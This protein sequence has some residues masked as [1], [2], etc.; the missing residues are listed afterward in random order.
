MGFRSY[1]IGDSSDG[2]RDAGAVLGGLSDE[3]Q[4]GTVPGGADLD[5]GHCRE[6]FLIQR[7]VWRHGA[8]Q[9]DTVGAEVAAGAAAGRE[10]DTV[11]GDPL[12]RRP[13]M[14]GDTQAVEAVHVL[15]L[16][17]VADFRR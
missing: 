12:Y 6:E 16:A 7:G 13:D 17:L 2:A 15:G 3:S 4:P 8:G 11:G 10:G 1:R 5:I 9:D 14:N